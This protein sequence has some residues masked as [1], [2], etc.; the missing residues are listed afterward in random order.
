MYPSFIVR[1]VC[2]SILLIK[3]QAAC[4]FLYMRRDPFCTLRPT[5]IL[6]IKRQ[7]PVIILNYVEAA[8]MATVTTDSSKFISSSSSSIA[9]R[10]NRVNLS[11]ILFVQKVLNHFIDLGHMECLEH[12]R[13]SPKKYTHRYVLFVA[14]L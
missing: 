1:S 12:V 7:A 10:N 5:S 2:T 3:R 9:D 4:F 6:L 8:T 11:T 14:K 13:N